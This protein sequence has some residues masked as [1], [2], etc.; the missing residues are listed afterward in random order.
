MGNILKI[1][2]ANPIQ[3]YQSGK[4]FFAG[5]NQYFMG[6][7]WFSNQSPDFYERINYLQKWQMTDS[8]YLQVQA[9]FGPVSWRI[10]NCSGTMIKEGS[11]LVIGEVPPGQIYTYYGANITLDDMPEG[12][13]YVL[14]LGGDPSDPIVTWI[15]EPQQLAVSWPYTVRVDYWALNDFAD[16]WF[17]VDTVFTIRV[18]ARINQYQP[19]AVSSVFT[20]Q[21]Q[22]YVQLSGTAFDAFKFH[23]GGSYGVP[24]WMIKKLNQIVC[25]PHW[26][27]E[28][29]EYVRL[30]DGAKFEPNRVERYPMAGWQLD[31]VLADNTL[32]DF[33][34]S[35]SNEQIA[36]VYNIDGLVFGTINNT[37]PSG[38]TII[39]IDNE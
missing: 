23:V 39:I 25:F 36:V 29:V 34:D 28:K 4:T 19:S 18:E 22:D 16:V 17:N 37:P 2:T 35:D 33:S 26:Q 20:D 11:F 27:V 1:P 31:V 32:Y 38:A 3:F 10:I 12:Q 21:T 7:D 5:K 15:S 8:I 30:N 14:I 6:E 24:D 13:F 9:N